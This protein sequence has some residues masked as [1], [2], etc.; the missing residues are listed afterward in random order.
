VRRVALAGPSRIGAPPYWHPQAGAAAETSGTAQWS[1]L[2]RWYRPAMFGLAALMLTVGLVV[3]INRY[4]AFAA[5]GYVGVDHAI[6]NVFA[7]RWWETGSMYLPAQIAGRFDPQLLTDDMTALPSMYP[8]T[9]VLLFVPFAVLPDVM[10][11]VVPLGTIGYVIARWRPAPWAW[12]L[13]AAVIAYPAT[14]SIVI[15]GNT[16]MWMVAGVCAALEWG[17]AGP[18]LL[19]KPSLAP[20][21]LIGIGRRTWWVALVVLVLVSVP[22]A[23]QWL[24]YAAVVGNAQTNLGYSLGTAPVFALPLVAWMARTAPPAA[25]SKATRRAVPLPRSTP[26]APH[27]A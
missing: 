10:W 1:G 13:L 23:G 16:A 21:A 14:S 3:A 17:W 9:A 22:F 8:P 18:L 15:V 24:A 6:H 4:G 12:P 20:L 27:R 19:L 7:L 11:W 25:G 26:P 5:L 2:I